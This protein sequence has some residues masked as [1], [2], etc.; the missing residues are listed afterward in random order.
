[1]EVVIGITGASGVIYAVKLLE[2]LKK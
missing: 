2:A 1:M